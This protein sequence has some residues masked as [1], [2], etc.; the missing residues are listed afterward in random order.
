M[1]LLDDI[2]RVRKKIGGPQKRSVLI[3]TPLGKTKSE[4]DSI[5]LSQF[6]I[7][8]ALSELGPCTA[9]ELSAETGM[10]EERIKQIAKGM[11]PQYVRLSGATE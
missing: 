9:R 6:K 5:P 2:S 10:S 4:S 11:M 8:S 3:L 1:G 7:L